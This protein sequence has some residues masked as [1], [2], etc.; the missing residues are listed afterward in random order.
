[1][2][3]RQPRSTCLECKNYS[4]VY[5]SIF[6][7][8]KC[9]ECQANV[10]SK[11]VEG[12]VAAFSV[13]KSNNPPILIPNYNA[14][15]CI[16]CLQCGGIAFRETYSAISACSLCKFSIPINYLHDALVAAYST[17]LIE[18]TYNSKY[19]VFGSKET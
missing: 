13:F 9:I 15:F 7:V 1:M 8:H 3:P 11:H 14:I 16:S 18:T 4:F 2:L 10:L 17:K 5:S 12:I 19:S 6:D